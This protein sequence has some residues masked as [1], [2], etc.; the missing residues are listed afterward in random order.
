MNEY[1]KKKKEIRTANHDNSFLLPL[2]IFC[3]FS[4]KKIN[5]LLMVLYREPS[6][7][8]QNRNSYLNPF[9]AT[10]K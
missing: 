10:S 9:E 4:K 2:L 3:F 5:S 6:S 1:F 8:T 7:T